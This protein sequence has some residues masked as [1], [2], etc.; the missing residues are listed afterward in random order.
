MNVKTP[1]DFPAGVFCKDE[2]ENS[3]RGARR[4]LLDGELLS[5]ICTVFAAI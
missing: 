4:L 5:K 1:A 2:Q 3:V